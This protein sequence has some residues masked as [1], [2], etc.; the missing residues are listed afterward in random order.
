[1]PPVVVKVQHE[2]SG[3]WARIP[4]CE[5]STSSSL[6]S[7]RDASASIGR[8]LKLHKFSL[9]VHPRSSRSAGP[10]ICSCSAPLEHVA[11]T[12]W[13][14]LLAAAGA[15][16]PHAATT[17]TLL[18]RSATASSPASWVDPFWA[19]ERT[20]LPQLRGIAA[21]WYWPKAMQGNAHPGA[22]LPFNTV[23][24]VPFSGAYP[25]GY[26]LN[27]AASGGIPELLR[28]RNGSPGVPA[29]TQAQRDA[30]PDQQYTTVGFT[31]FQP[32]G[33]GSI[34]N[35]MNYAKVTGSRASKPRAPHARAHDAV[36]RARRR[37][38]CR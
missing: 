1:M 31:H 25:S 29:E 12:E 27:G 35:Y 11:Q 10:E 33:T 6:P 8:S 17:I 3:R 16:G 20:D 5:A 36:V 38:R 14:A 28:S 32:S 7:F 37:C 24:V 34:G 18:A 21:A 4:L 22:T 30:M 9:H 13:A 2:D 23:S 19:C 15:H 26:G